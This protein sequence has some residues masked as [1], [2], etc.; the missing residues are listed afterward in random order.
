MS[1]PGQAVGG[2]VGAVAGFFLG[3]G[4]MGAVYGA[5][6]GLM[7]GGMLD[8]P[9]G[10]TI[11]GPG[12]DDLTVQTSTYGSVIPRVYGTV[13]VAGNVFWLENNRLKETI[14]KKYAGHQQSAPCRV[15]PQRS[16]STF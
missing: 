2:L 1:T 15:Q 16:R 11:D 10:P 9:K 3:G 8:P 4:P 6:A 13:A 5:Q 14:T 7:L 12:L